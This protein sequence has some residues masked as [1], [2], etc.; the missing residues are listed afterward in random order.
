MVSYSLIEQKISSLTLE[1]FAAKVFFGL[2]ETKHGT[3]LHGIRIM[4]ASVENSLCIK[5][6]DLF[7]IYGLFIKNL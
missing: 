2:S 7:T 3:N 5:R 6:T 1:V 4:L